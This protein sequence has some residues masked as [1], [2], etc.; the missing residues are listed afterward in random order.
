M[1]PLN[2]SCISPITVIIGSSVA[3]HES[4]S[5][6]TE[7]V[8]F[9][10]TGERT[11]QGGPLSIETVSAIGSDFDFVLSRLPRHA[12]LVRAA[13]DLTVASGLVRFQAAATLI[14][15]DIRER[16]YRRTWPAMRRRRDIRKQFVLACSVKMMHDYAVSYWGYPHVGSREAGEWYSTISKEVPSSDLALWHSLAKLEYRRIIAHL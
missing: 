2:H 13:I 16:N 6:A 5:L 1:G 11:S 9:N 15:N 7:E 8:T 4:L 12:A 10:E 3:A 14:L